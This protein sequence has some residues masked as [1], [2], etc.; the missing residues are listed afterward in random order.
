MKWTVNGHLIVH[1]LSRRGADPC[2][3]SAGRKESL[4][5]VKAAALAGGSAAQEGRPHVGT[6]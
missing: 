5:L 3:R 4:T 2:W 1:Y 6:A